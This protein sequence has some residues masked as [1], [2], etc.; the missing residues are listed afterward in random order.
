LYVVGGSEALKAHD[1][2]GLEPLGCSYAEFK[3]RLM[4]E[5]H[6][7][8]RAL[9]DPHLFSGIGNAYSDEILHAAGLSPL[10]L[11]SRLDGDETRRL[12]DSVRSTLVF[13]SDK[14]RKEARE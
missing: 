4:S 12:F 1:R 7:L 2:G 6:T 13:W 10:K 14:L 11:T 3:Q 8:K 5:N 9:T